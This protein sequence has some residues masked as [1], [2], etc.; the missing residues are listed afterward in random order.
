MKFQ[1]IFKKESSKFQL[2]FL[3]LKR[4]Q[5]S[6]RK[7][8]HFSL[9]RVTKKKIE[10]YKKRLQPLTS[11]QL[12]MIRGLLL[13]GKGQLREQRSKEKVSF[14]FYMEDS[15][16]KLDFVYQA[17]SKFESGPNS[18]YSW[19]NLRP[20][21]IIKKVSL[22]KKTFFSQWNKV[23]F[24]TFSTDQLS[25]LNKDFYGPSNAFSVKNV[26]NGSRKFRRGKTQSGPQRIPTKTFRDLFF[27]NKEVLSFWQFGSGF[28]RQGQ[29]FLDL[30]VY[31]KA[32]VE[33]IIF[34][35]NQ[36]FN[37]KVNSL[38]AFMELSG[39]FIFED[40]LKS[41]KGFSS[42]SMKK[43]E[44]FLGWYL[45]SASNF[46]KK[47]EKV[48]IVQENQSNFFSLISEEF[49]GFNEQKLLFPLQ[50]FNNFYDFKKPLRISKED[51]N[52]AQF[53]KKLLIYSYQH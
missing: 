40:L 53:R 14:S 43:K 16:E 10:A 20:K 28:Y 33:F 49:Y 52:E 19:V 47:A 9:Q 25:E 27:L 46:R 32:E 41:R 8:A 18:G 29:F 51:Q 26:N 4:R 17:F 6:Q 31:S 39:N 44:G 24:N 5:R 22:G 3:I 37:F 36:N 23:S 11:Y 13:S 50:E 35:I 34:Q 15:L 42:K 21:K 7:K 2:T 30:Q 1:R 12:N 38:A 45:L 48:L